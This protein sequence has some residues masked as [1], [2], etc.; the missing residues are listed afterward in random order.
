MRPI[1]STPPNESGTSLATPE[2][3]FKMLEANFYGK[4]NVQQSRQLRLESF[5]RRGD[6]IKRKAAVSKWR[7]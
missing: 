4:N 1:E 3:I 7:K 2:E 5:K 6:I